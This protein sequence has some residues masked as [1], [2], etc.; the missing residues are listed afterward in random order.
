MVYLSDKNSSNSSLSGNSGDRQKLQGSGHMTETKLDFLVLRLRT[1]GIDIC[2]NACKR[3]GFALAGL[4]KN[5]CICR[6]EQ[7]LSGAEMLDDEECSTVCDDSSGYCGGG[8][9]EKEASFYN[10]T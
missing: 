9:T 10:V 6:T 7:G 1:N 2:I 5:L 8:K 4:K 3:E